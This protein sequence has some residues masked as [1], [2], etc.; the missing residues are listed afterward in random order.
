MDKENNM[1]LG[2]FIKQNI[3]I[4]LYIFKMFCM[5]KMFLNFKMFMEKNGME[6]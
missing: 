2:L 6:Y 5:L 1:G 4:M 3:L